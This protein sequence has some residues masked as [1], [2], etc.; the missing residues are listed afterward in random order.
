MFEIVSVPIEETRAKD[1]RAW[2]AKGECG[3]LKIVVGAK[4]RLALEEAVSLASKSS[5]RN[6]Y[7]QQSILELDKAD[8]YRHALEVLDEIINPDTVLE[9]LKL[10]G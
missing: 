2:L 9:T 7:E 5:K 4:L 1:L 10:N 8:R 3:T 6:S